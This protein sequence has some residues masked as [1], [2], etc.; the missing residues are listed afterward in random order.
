MIKRTPR[1]AW[2]ASCVRNSIVLAIALVVGAACNKPDDG[3]YATD[4]KGDIAE[5]AWA[6]V[7]MDFDKLAQPKS[8]PFVELAGVHCGGCKKNLKL[9][10]QLAEVRPDISFR[11]VTFPEEL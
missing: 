8:L 7:H 10:K 9:M 1:P 4:A 3:R 2:R 6:D 5:V 11:V